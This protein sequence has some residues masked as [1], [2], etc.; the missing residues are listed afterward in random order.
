VRVAESV[1][2][3]QIVYPTWKK[4]SSWYMVAKREKGALI[5]Q[6]AKHSGH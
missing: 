4:T 2:T 1:F 5:E 3:A 6:A